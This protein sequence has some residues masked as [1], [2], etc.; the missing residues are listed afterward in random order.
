MR[1][2]GNQIKIQL[3]RKVRERSMTFCREKNFIWVVCKRSKSKTEINAAVSQSESWGEQCNRF[4][5]CIFVIC[6]GIYKMNYLRLEFEI[7]PCDMCAG[8]LLRL[9]IRCQFMGAIVKK[10]VERLQRGAL[11]WRE[12]VHFSSA[13]NCRRLSIRIGIFFFSPAT[14]F[15]IFKFIFLYFCCNIFQIRSISR[16]LQRICGGGI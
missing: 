3:K 8:I 7:M 14:V 13:C 10:H 15:F 16:L 6:M 4:C 1:V 12:F 11:V 2:C 9:W 5:W